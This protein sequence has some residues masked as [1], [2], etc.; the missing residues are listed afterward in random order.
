MWLPDQRFSCHLF[1]SQSLV[2]ACI[3]GRLN[4]CPLEEGWGKQTYFR[5]DDKRLQPPFNKPPIPESILIK[6]FDY[7]FP[8][9]PRPRPSVAAADTGSGW[10]YSQQGGNSSTRLPFC[11]SHRHLRFNKNKKYWPSSVYLTNTDLLGVSCSII[12][13]RTEGKICNIHFDKCPMLFHSGPWMD[14]ENVQRASYETWDWLF[15][16]Q[17]APASKHSIWSSQIRYTV[18]VF[19]ES[20]RHLFLD[21]SLLG[22]Y[23][24]RTV[25]FNL[26]NIE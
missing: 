11:S 12:Q 19:D 26:Y 23:S 20:W 3:W 9:N 17:L 13:L 24:V 6:V 4:V 18:F 21:L 1:Q 14:W 25:E 5:L 2:C 8:S 22:I 10:S 7:Q 15:R 16:V